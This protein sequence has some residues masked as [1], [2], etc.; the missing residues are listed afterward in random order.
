MSTAFLYHDDCTLHDMGN[1]HPESPFR[2]EAI[3]DKLKQTGLLDDLDEITPQEVDRK[4]LQG[5]HPESYIAQLEAHRPGEGCIM[6]DPDTGLMKTSMHAAYL[7]SGATI[8]ATDMVLSGQIDTAFCAVRPPGH[9]AERNKTMGFCFF[10]NIA[11]AAAHAL[12][13]HNLER[14]AIV[15]FDVHQ[16]NGTI[17]IFQ[18]DPRVLVCSS[19]EYPLYPY[20]HFDIDSP[21]IVNS[22]L[23]AYSKGLQ[24]RRTVERDWFHRLQDHKPQLIL[25]SAGFDAH[26]HDPLANLELEEKDYRWVTNM[27]M[28]VAKSYSQGRI[29]STLEGGY[30]L[31]AL[32]SS[33]EAHMQ[34]LASL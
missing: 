22:P 29:V 4:Y 20:S 13:F 17:D 14:V 21:N 6:V 1:G 5:V 8:E 33:V 31:R 28:D 26:K 11:V 7:A 12:N 23:E 15:D 24:F 9:H 25:I 18:N 19:F 2:I 30:N 16:A 3:R 10:N 27:L 34:G 32:A